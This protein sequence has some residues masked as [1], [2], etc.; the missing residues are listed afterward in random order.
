MR[1]APNLVMSGTQPA[2]A[3]GMH[4]PI[5][6]RRVFVWD[7]CTVPWGILTGNIDEIESLTIGAQSCTWTG[8]GRKMFTVHG[9]YIKWPYSM[10]FAG[11]SG[12][13][14]TNAP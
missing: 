4:W 10:K 14:P 2:A 3:L 12:V 1:S 5:D 11:S 8:S 6:H 13:Y 7:V 9:D